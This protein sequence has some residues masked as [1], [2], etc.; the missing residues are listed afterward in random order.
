MNILKG[1]FRKTNGHNNLKVENNTIV[2]ELDDSVCVDE[3]IFVDNTPPSAKSDIQPVN[4]GIQE[5]L[6]HNFEGEGYND[7]YNLHSNDMLENKIK[8]I[9]ANFRYK[10]DIKADQVRNEILNLENKKLEINGL[11]EQMEVR[12]ENHI[13]EKRYILQKLKTEKELSSVDEGL[14]MTCIYKYREGY[15]KGTNAYL[16]EELIASNKGLF[17]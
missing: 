17:N 7:G 9:K 11:L 16:E 15:I 10:L 2:D 8:L 3:N 12:I 5:F 4:A 1:F 13:S 14:V 6:N